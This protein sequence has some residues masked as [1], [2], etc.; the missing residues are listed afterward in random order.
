MYY[1]GVQNYSCLFEN[2]RPSAA[3]QL[4]TPMHNQL[5][6]FGKFKLNYLNL[7]PFLLLNPVFPNEE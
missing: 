1:R 3:R 7:V 5:A 2:S 6:N 4:G